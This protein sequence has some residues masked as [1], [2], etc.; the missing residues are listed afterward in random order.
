MYTTLCCTYACTW[1]HGQCVS[2]QIQTFEHVN[3]P[4]TQAN[5]LA[6][7]EFGKDLEAQI[8]KLQFLAVLVFAAYASG[9]TM[10]VTNHPVGAEALL[11]VGASGRVTDIMFIMLH[12][13]NNIGEL[14]CLWDRLSNDALSNILVL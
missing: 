9:L 10:I 6:I 1:R 7:H 14:H 2:D 12:R 11:P 3:Q 4:I 8:G 5:C 13:N